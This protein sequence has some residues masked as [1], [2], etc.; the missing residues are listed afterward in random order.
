MTWR[1]GMD[2]VF[3]ALADRSRRLLMDRL[4]HSNGQTL[5]QLCA[6][7]GMARP[8][9][10]KHLAVLEAANLHHDPPRTRKT[11]LPGK[12]C[13]STSHPTSGLP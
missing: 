8:S 3:K 13:W 10:T 2:E 9:V 4:N 1:E 12:H 11:P 6:G 5:R 7:L